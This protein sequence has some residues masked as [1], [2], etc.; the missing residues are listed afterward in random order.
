MRPSKNNDYQYFLMKLG[1]FSC[2]FASFSAPAG[3]L[4]FSAD[5]AILNVVKGV[6]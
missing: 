6:K 4:H 5:H 3:L 2:T 1:V